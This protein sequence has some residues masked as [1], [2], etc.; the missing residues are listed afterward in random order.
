MSLWSIIASLFSNVNAGENNPPTVGTSEAFSATGGGKTMKLMSYRKV[1]TNNSTTS[2]LFIDANTVQECFILEPACRAPGVKVPN[3][4]AI[5]SGTYNITM[6]MSA[7]FGFL[8]PHLSNQPDNV[9]II[10]TQTDASGQPVTLTWQYVEIH[11]GNFE[12]S[13]NDG[14]IEFD[15]DACLLPGATAGVDYVSQSQATSKALYSKIVAGLAQGKVEICII[16]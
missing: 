10:V 2:N 6:Q 11:P 15:S 12:G 5:P 3:R 16:G 4:T 1:Y 14:K 13:E 8:T 7:R 9:T